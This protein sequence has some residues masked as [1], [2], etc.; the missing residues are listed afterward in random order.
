MKDD[1]EVLDVAPARKT[2]TPKKPVAKKTAKATSKTPEA[3]A[4]AE[5]PE[6]ASS[7]P[8]Q[9]SSDDTA[10][11]SESITVKSAKEIVQVEVT[12]G[13]TEVTVT[14]KKGIEEVEE[15]ATS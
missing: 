5:V 11:G 7:E 13:K 4:D 8:A 15:V 1:A 12:N 10:H 9:L 14:E 2:I 3:D 6:K